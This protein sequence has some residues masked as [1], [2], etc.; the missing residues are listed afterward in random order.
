[1]SE[2][3]SFVAAA[4]RLELG[5][6]ILIDVR[7]HKTLTPNF[8]LGNQACGT[9]DD[10]FVPIPNSWTHSL[11][12]FFRHRFVCSAALNLDS[13]TSSHCIDLILMMRSFEFT[14]DRDDGPTVGASCRC[15]NL[16]TSIGGTRSKVEGEDRHDLEPEGTREDTRHKI[17]TGLVLFPGGIG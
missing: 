2:C 17:Y 3:F 9:T 15:L 13:P 6:E 16:S 1:M 10:C 4:A 14:G 11:S 5:P 8:F 7:Q 12:R